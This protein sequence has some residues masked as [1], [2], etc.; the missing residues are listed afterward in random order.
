MFGAWA[1]TTQPIPFGLVRC[2]AAGQGFGAWAAG[3]ER[4][5]HQ[6]G[7]MVGRA[8]VGSAKVENPCSLSQFVPKNSKKR[9]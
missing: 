2:C 3:R 4:A 7:G 6:S 5:R 1:P 8:G 9:T